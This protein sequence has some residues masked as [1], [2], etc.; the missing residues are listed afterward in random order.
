MKSLM[1]KVNSGELCHGHI[2]SHPTAVKIDAASI[3]M[4][5]IGSHQASAVEAAN[6]A[7]K[8]LASAPLVA[9]NR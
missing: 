8:R 2:S 4:N 6:V 7:I 3:F 1:K 5:P 9:L